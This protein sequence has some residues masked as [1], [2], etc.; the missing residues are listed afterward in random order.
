MRLRP[1]N[2]RSPYVKMFDYAMVAGV[3][4]QVMNVTQGDNS[5]VTLVFENYETKELSVDDYIEILRE[6]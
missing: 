5:R 6:A 2:T 1:I 4:Q 3:Y